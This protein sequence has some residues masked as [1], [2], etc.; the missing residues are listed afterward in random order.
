VKSPRKKND[1]QKGCSSFELLGEGI[2]QYINRKTKVV[3]MPSQ[4]NEGAGTAEVLHAQL[5]EADK[6][7]RYEKD[8]SDS[9]TE[10]EPDLAK[11]E[12]MKCLCQHNVDLGLSK[13]KGA[14]FGAIAMVDIPKGTRLFRCNGPPTTETIALTEDDI[15]ELP[16]HVQGVVRMYTQSDADNGGVRHVPKNGFLFVL[17]ISW[18]INS[19]DGTDFEPNVEVGANLD[20]SGF[21]ELIAL[22]DIEP[23]E[24]LLDSYKL[25]RQRGRGKKLL[26]P[27]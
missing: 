15:E 11:E 21:A 27:L 7:A 5:N 14:R 25:R 10:C 20:E 26:V 8:S 1:G 4:A 16:L 2:K 3:E 18:R 6:D 22:R 17:G 13:I 9:R 12:L 24:E 19:V 23:G